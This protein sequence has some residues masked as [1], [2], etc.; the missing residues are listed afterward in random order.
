MREGGP[1]CTK[2][3][4]PGQTRDDFLTKDTMMNLLLKNRKMIRLTM[5]EKTAQGP[6]GKIRWRDKFHCVSF[7]IGFMGN[8]FLS[9]ILAV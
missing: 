7:N 3:F 4:F 5:G 1:G 8:Q 6:K 2:V 9:T